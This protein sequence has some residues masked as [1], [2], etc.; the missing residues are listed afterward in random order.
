MLAILVLDSPDAHRSG[1]DTAASACQHFS[2]MNSRRH[3]LA[4]T[5]AAA[6]GTLG[7][8]AFAQSLKPQGENISFGL[9]TYMWGAEW[10]IPAIL[11]NLTGLGIAGVELREQHAHGVS[12]ALTQ[13][14]RAAVRSQFADA[15][16]EIVGMGTNC[17]FDSPDKAN[18]EKN[19]E[20]AKEWIKLSHDVGGSGVKVKP[21]KLHEKEGVPRDQTLE[22]IGKAL[23]QLGDYAIGFGQEVRLEVHGQ[24][25]KLADI[26]KVMEVA[27]ADN[28]RVCWNSNPADLEE[29][30]LEKNFAL[31]KDYLGHT[32]HVRELGD[33]KYPFATLMKLLVDADY[34]GWVL[35]EAA[36]K[37]ED[38][39][40]ALGEQKDLWEKMVTDAR[41]G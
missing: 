31:V 17:M 30:G 4:Q 15:G 9:V 29:G 7:L 16:I 25:T 18:V 33:P 38:K 11:K 1:I 26:R 32:T 34:D 40:K 2:L 41:K 24:V 12:P 10:D 13:D 37:P 3:F 21:D 36:S 6:A 28:V 22:Q 39:V 20:L 8:S 14:Q 5:A 27:D 19:V 35:M 23:A